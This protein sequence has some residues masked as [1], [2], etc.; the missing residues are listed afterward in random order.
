MV[1]AG[2]TLHEG[3]TSFLGV[4]HGTFRHDGHTDAEEDIHPASHTL[5]DKDE[6]LHVVVPDMAQP[7]LGAA[8]DPYSWDEQ[9]DGHPWV[10]A[11]DAEDECGAALA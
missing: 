3:D 2:R 5:L 6:V 10:E 4:R 7:A 1:D 9:V 11:V 8:V